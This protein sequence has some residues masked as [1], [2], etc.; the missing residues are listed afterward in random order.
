ML[1]QP[2]KVAQIK[3]S[4]AN[5]EAFS[6]NSEELASINQKLDNLDSIARVEWAMANLPGQHIMSSSFGAQSAVM[7]HLVN[8]VAPG[9]P[10]VLTDTGYLFPETYRFI[11]TL[12]QQLDLNLKVYRAPISAAWQEARFGR[13]WENGSDELAKYNEL[14]KVEPMKRALADLHA[15][16]WFAGLRRS[17]SDTRQ[18]LNVVQKQAN[19]WK[20]HP[21]IDLNN[22]QLHHYMKKHKL[23]YH[24]LWEQ[25]YVSVGDWHTTRPLEAGMS[26][27]E[28]RFFGMNRECGLHEFG[29]GDGI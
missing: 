5:A 17:Q 4:N 2:T 24:P 18:H 28:T 15:Q 27:Q 29:D 14:N 11:D 12:S 13:R 20:V 26:E 8:Q 9:I 22:Q 6:L 25:G 10:V 3:A 23:P 21:I 19:Q 7:L 16:T 1:S